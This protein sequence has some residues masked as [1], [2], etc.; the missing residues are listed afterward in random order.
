MST[1]RAYV[2]FD[3]GAESGRAMLAI[4]E[5]EKLTLQECHRFANLPQ[6]LPSGYHWNLLDIWRHLVEGLKQAGIKAK[7]LDAELVSLG[8]DT[9]GVDFGLLGK[10]GQLL[11]LPFCYRDDRNPPAM[12]A[13]HDQL[14]AD[15]VY[16]QT[17]IQHMPFNSIYQLKAQQ[18]TEQCVLQNATDM[19]FMPDLLHY[20]FSGEKVNEATIASTSQMVNPHTGKWNTDL[21]DKAAIPHEFLKNIVPAGTIIGKLRQAIAKEAGVEP[22]DVIV[23][24]SH[25]TASAIASVPVDQANSGNWLYLS[26]GT[27]SLMGAE[28]DKPIVND[29]SLKANYTNERGVEDKIRFLKNISGLWLVQECR[30]DLIRKGQD[31]DYGTLAQMAADSE[32]FVTLIDTNHAPFASPGDMLAKID[33]YAKATGQPAPTTPGGYVRAC[34]ESLAMTYRNVCLDIEALTDQSID[35]LHIVGG[36]G[37]NSLLNQMTADAINKPVIVGPFEATAIGNALTQAMGCGD[38]KNLDHIRRIVRNSFDLETYKPT[39]ALAYDAQAT[40]YADL[41]AKAV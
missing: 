10:S 24:G 7:Q 28:L 30:R 2:A 29:A 8:V 12:A 23:P 1:K 5:N 4:L 11:G 9:W 6:Q 39:D 3:L 35:V 15:E 27:W 18:A 32:P 26:S 21:L 13:V 36:G 33:A 31:L 40:R 14:G 22:I 17:G 34:L 20:F 41:Q 16:L 25:D 37:K 19:L 38:V